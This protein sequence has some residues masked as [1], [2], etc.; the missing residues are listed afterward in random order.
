MQ[1]DLSAKHIAARPTPKT[2]GPGT[3]PGCLLSINGL[4]LL[5]HPAQ[6]AVC[7]RAFGAARNAARWQNLAGSFRDVRNGAL[8]GVVFAQAIGYMLTS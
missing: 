6:A 7:G 5:S 1:Y 4:D 3:L 8:A 2:P